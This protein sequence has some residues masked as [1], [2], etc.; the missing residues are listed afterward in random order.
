MPTHQSLAFAA[1][2]GMLAL[3]APALGQPAEPYEFAE[4]ADAEAIY[5]PD[6][7][8]QPLSMPSPM[9]PAVSGHLPDARN[10]AAAPLRVSPSPLAGVPHAWNSYTPPLPHRTCPHFYAME[11]GRMPPFERDAWLLNCRERIRGVRRDERGAVI[12]GL[13]GAAAGGL[14]GNRAWDSE[15]LAGTLLGAGVGGLG[16]AA[17]GTAIGAAGDRRRQDDCAWYLDRLMADYSGY[18]YL[19]TGVGYGYAYPAVAYVPVP[20]WVPQR[21]VIRETVTEEWVNEPVRARSMSHTATMLQRASAPDKRRKL[22][23]IR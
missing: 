15:R 6:P 1:V 7:V 23:K 8:I 9:A 10:E 4:E 17:I 14:I 3:A 12:G 13:L 19:P 22:T 2:T 16:G 21:A 18:G 11:H 20:V 5:H